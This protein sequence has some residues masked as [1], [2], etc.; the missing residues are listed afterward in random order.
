[1]TCGIQLVQ[2]ARRN[3]SMERS[4]ASSWFQLAERRAVRAEP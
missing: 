2:A 1:M 4:Q 3:A